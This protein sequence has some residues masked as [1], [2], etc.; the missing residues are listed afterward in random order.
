MS[1]RGDEVVLIDDGGGGPSSSSLSRLAGA[2]VK[3]TFSEESIFTRYRWRLRRVVDSVYM[4]LFC[5]LLVLVDAICFFVRL[6]SV[7]WSLDNDA[8]AAVE[9]PGLE[10]FTFILT[11]YFLVDLSARLVAHGLHFFRDPWNVFDFVIIVTSVV[12]EFTEQIGRILILARLARLVLIARLVNEQRRLKAG[13]RQ[14]ISQNKRRYQEGGF[15]LDLTYVTERVIA[16]SFPSTGTTALYRNPMGDVQRFFKTVHPQHYLIYNLCAERAYDSSKF[17]GR[18]KRYRI[19]DHNVPPLRD[20]LR[21]CQDA[22]EFMQESEENVI[23][24]HCKGGKGRTGTMICSWLLT[25]E[26]QPT[27]RAALDYFAQRRTDLRVSTQFQGVQT[28]SQYRYVGYIEEI[29]KKYGGSLPEPAPIRH[30]KAIRVHG[31]RP[32]SDNKKNKNKNTTSLSS[33]SSASSSSAAPPLTV[34]VFSGMAGTR[35]FPSP[36]GGGGGGGGGDGSSS[37]NNTA[38][39]FPPEAPTPAGALEAPLMVFNFDGGGREGEGGGLEVAG[40][41][42]IKFHGMNLPKKYDKCPF[43]FWFHTQ[44]VEGHNQLRIDRPDLDNPHKPKSWSYFL[45]DLA[46]EVVF[47]ASG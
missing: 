44:F 2:A 26:T 28:P 38:E 37:N 19:D 14:K 21:F 31:C 40:D 47:A 15:D 42:K 41:V 32:K 27:A 20:I 34:E 10:T 25:T 4:R 1:T 11:I 17:E 36:A 39:L 13:L 5:M 30:I 22:T 8:N 24:V 3:D 6:A 46:V 12:L 45:E 9:D 33:S 18:V 7:G 23:S 43:Y 29:I 16:M 35:V